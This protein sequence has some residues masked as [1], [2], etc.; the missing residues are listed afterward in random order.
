M[1][2]V[3]G[4]GCAGACS[5]VT[6]SK[7]LISP[8]SFCLFLC[9]LWLQ[10]SQE[11]ALKWLPMRVQTKAAN[12]HTHTYV[13]AFECVCLLQLQKKMKKIRQKSLLEVVVEFCTFFFL[14]LSCNVQMEKEL[15]IFYSCCSAQHMR[16]YAIDFSSFF[17]RVFQRCCIVCTPLT[18]LP[19]FLVFLRFLVHLPVK[20]HSTWLLLICRCPSRCA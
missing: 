17:L 9:P 8:P 14:F 10:F 7:G 15:Q 20:G 1:G 16:H 5:L 13:Y 19:G 18:F 4:E 3:L 12:T 11:A 6:S 2:L